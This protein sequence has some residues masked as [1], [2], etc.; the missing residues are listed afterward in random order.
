MP[1]REQPIY[2]H[3]GVGGETPT[4]F[5]MDGLAYPQIDPIVLDFPRIKEWWGIV[6]K[7]AKL[8]FRPANF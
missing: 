2:R 4:M 3:I 5:G 1:L 7:S 6:W 8:S